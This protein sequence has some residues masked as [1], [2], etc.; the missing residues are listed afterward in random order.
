MW[1]VTCTFKD[2]LLRHSQLSNV[3]PWKRKSP[4]VTMTASSLSNINIPAWWLCSPGAKPLFQFHLESS[5]WML[6]MF[7]QYIYF[8]PCLFYLVVSRWCANLSLRDVL[9]SSKLRSKQSS[10]GAAWEAGVGYRW[11][12]TLG[13]PAC[14][15]LQWKQKQSNGVC[16]CVCVHSNPSVNWNVLLLAARPRQLRC[17]MQPKIWFVSLWNIIY[18]HFG[19][20]VSD[21]HCLV[22]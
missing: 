12:S 7:P 9:I 6:E 21:V 10:W 8:S 4:A 22:F 15:K 14:Y 11:E 2:L 3:A 18:M 16:V 1:Q 20:K 5:P 17:E 13:T 19:E